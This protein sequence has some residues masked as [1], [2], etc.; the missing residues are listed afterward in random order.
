M[1][2]KTKALTLKATDYKENDKLILLYSLEY[3]KISTYARGI[4]KGTAKLKFAAE[5][6]NLADFEIISTHDHYTVKTATQLESF[7]DVRA[8]IGAYLA[9]CT[10]CDVL[11]T[12]EEEGQPNGDVFVLAL[13]ALQQLES[14]PE[15]CFKVVLH[16]LLKYLKI[17]GTMPDFSTCSACGSAIGKV[18]YID[19]QQGGAVCENCRTPHSI[20]VSGGCTAVFNLASAVSVDKLKN[21]NITDSQLKDCLKI[22]ATYIEHST[23]KVNSLAELLKL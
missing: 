5:P 13:R 14:T 8:D 18:C 10:V 21:V 15:Q 16:F 6:F 2:L 20:A 7:F 19:L 1:E 23:A 12:V 11:A 17:N 3:G 4:R 22:L 9:A